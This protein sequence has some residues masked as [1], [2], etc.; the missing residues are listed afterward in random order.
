[1]YS[2]HVIGEAEHVRW[3]Q[4]ALTRADRRYWIILMDEHPVGLA[5]LARIDIVNRRCDWAYYLGETE[6]RGKGVGACVEYMVL[7]EVFGPMGLNK[8]TCEVFAENESVVRL[9]ESFGFAREA[10]F[11]EHVWKGGRFRNVWGMGM[12]AA[13]WARARRGVEDRLRER[14]VDPAALEIRVA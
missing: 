5:N 13:D 12:L 10:N 4:A 2:D 8:L 11:R 7:R 3:A 9:H 1:M 6:T 14:G